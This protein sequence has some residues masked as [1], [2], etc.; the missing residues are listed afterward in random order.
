MEGG[1][2]LGG[3]SWNRDGGGN[4]REMQTEGWEKKKMG[5][6]EK[7]DQEEEGQE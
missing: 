6:V 7:R 1:E 2:K 3:D 5:I 4:R